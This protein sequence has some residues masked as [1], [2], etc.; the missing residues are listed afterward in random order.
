MSVVRRAANF[1][2]EM[3]VLGLTDSDQLKEVVDF[4]GTCARLLGLTVLD[5]Q[6]GKVY[7]PFPATSG[8]SYYVVVRGIRDG[9][10]K[11]QVLASLLRLFPRDPGHVRKMFDVRL[12]YGKRGIDLLTAVQYQALLSSLGCACA[13][14]PEQ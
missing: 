10:T 13:Y 12:A 5:P 7:R 2:S 11:D 3:A 8:A 4:V 9:F 1:G 14:G 6:E